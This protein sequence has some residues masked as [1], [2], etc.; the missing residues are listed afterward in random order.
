MESSKA[1]VESSLVLLTE[2]GGTQGLNWNVQKLLIR[3]ESV[4]QKRIF[5]INPNH[6]TQHNDSFVALGALYAECHI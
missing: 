3:A 1:W 2:M 6:Y 5:V 4:S